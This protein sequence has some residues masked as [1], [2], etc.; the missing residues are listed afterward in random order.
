ATVRSGID[1]FDLEG[2]VSYGGVEV[3]LADLLEAHRRGDESIEL[4]DGSRALLPTEWLSRLGAVAAGGDTTNGAGR[5]A[6][7]P[8]ALLDAPRIARAGPSLVVVPRSL[9]FNWIREAER[10][11]PRLRVVDQS[12]AGRKTAGIDADA[13]LV[14]TTYG[15][16][17]RD[18][19]LLAGTEFDYVILDEAQAIKNA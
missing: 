19:P 2:G 5:F 8:T 11:T 4:E 13:N 3:P 9:V 17:R 15:T 18:A 16:L 14:L 10:F 7:T 1:W 12:R 6:K